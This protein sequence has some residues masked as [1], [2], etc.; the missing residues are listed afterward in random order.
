MSTPKTQYHW[1]I[2][3]L[4]T[5]II[6]VNVQ[7]SA[8]SFVLTPP[9][10]GNR[11]VLNNLLPTNT[12]PTSGYGDT[13]FAL[14]LERAITAWNDVGVGHLPDHNFFSSLETPQDRDWCQMDG[15]STVVLTPSQCGLDWGDTVGMNIARWIEVRNPDGSVDGARSRDYETDILFNSRTAWNAYPGPTQRAEEGGLL[16][17]FLRVA[18]HEVGHSMGLDHPDQH[19][20]NVI[21]IMKSSDTLGDAIDTIQPDDIAGAHA[22]KF[23]LLTAATPLKTSTTP[24]PLPP[25]VAQTPIP[26]PI[27]TTLPL[28][29]SGTLKKLK[30]KIKNSG[31]VLVLKLAFTQLGGPLPNQCIMASVFL[32]RDIILDLNDKLLTQRCIDENIRTNTAA[33]LKFKNLEA[34]MN[35][36][37]VV[38]IDHTEVIEETDELNNIIVEQIPQR[39][40]VKDTLLTEQEQVG[41]INAGGIRPNDSIR[42]RGAIN[43][44]GDRDV[45]RLKVKDAQTVRLTLTHAT[46]NNFD[47]L[48]ADGLTGEQFGSCITNVMPETCTFTYSRPLLTDITIIPGSRLGPYTLNIDSAPRKITPP[49]S[50]TTDTIPQ[51]PKPPSPTTLPLPPNPPSPTTLPQQPVPQI[52]LSMAITGTGNVTSTPR[53]IL[54]GNTCE[55]AFDAGTRITLT[56][57]PSPGFAFSGW[58]GSK[59]F[60]TAPCT[61][62]LLENTS[63]NALFEKA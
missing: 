17:D 26:L 44:P 6:M 50:P 10:P 18:I 51:T 38:S 32:S 3:T 25:P 27:P 41:P 42:I 56:A 4:A 57:F 46:S 45:Y 33:K 55:A 52:R 5:C 22:V 60:G 11:V 30:H 8:H 36:F 7:N 20:Q 34:M 24:L 9:T 23:P 12:N 19:G 63:L 43:F 61:I 14:L 54:C 29:L 2:A 35:L 58:R 47:L 59:C 16:L 13:S 53:G 37:I 1:I 15:F 48:V 28:D 21:S 31:D 49:Q 62:T 39:E 40:S